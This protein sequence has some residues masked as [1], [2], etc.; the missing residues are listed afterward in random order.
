[1]RSRRV[2]LAAACAAV[3]VTVAAGCGP[4]VK[5]GLT[6][7]GDKA[8]ATFD[9]PMV[10]EDKLG[11]PVANPPLR[12][13]PA[14]PGIFRWLD[15]KVIAFV[16]EEALPRSSKIEMEVPAGVKALDGFGIAKAVKWSFET[17]R[18]HVSSRNA[19]TNG[20]RV[21]S[22]SRSPS[23]SRCAAATSRSDVATSPSAAASRRSSTTPARTV[24]RDKFAVFPHEPLAL[25]TKWRF[26]CSAELT[27]A[28]GPLGLEID[29]KKPA[30][31]S[32][33]PTGR[34][35]SRRSRL[36]R[37]AFTRPRQH[38]HQLLHPRRRE[39]R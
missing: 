22:A 34:S 14:V 27:G 15:A 28:E 16:P 9:R 21:T 38:R 23:T 36:R 26:E 8:T 4:K 17:E 1:M 11:V 37:P 29:A 20:R 31:S 12:M 39:R 7:A 10:G 33:R 5:P 25:A 30:A 18:L 2:L 3:A 6:V 13:K 32:S 19:P 35:R 24:R